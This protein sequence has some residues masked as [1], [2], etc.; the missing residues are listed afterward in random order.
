M[1]TGTY[2]SVHAYRYIHACAH[3]SSVLQ[4]LLGKDVQETDG[5]NV[6]RCT[7]G[8][9][10]SSLQLTGRDLFSVW[11]FAGQIESFITHHFFISTQSTVIA[12]LVDMTSSLDDQKAQLLRWLGFIKVR[13]LGHVRSV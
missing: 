3:T 12:V 10:V 9:E 5:A 2:R 6:N 4:K 7:F 11:D 13:N 1:H 8:I